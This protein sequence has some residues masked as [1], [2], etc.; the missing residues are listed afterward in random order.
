MPTFIENWEASTGR[1]VTREDLLIAE[2]AV[3]IGWE[4]EYHQNDIYFGRTFEKGQIPNHSLTFVRPER[5]IWDCGRLSMN[6]AIGVEQKWQCRD[7]DPVTKILAPK[8]KGRFYATI[9]QAL[10]TESLGQD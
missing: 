6:R 2:F 1:K 10:A 3:S 8:N 5:V 7:R 4:I 9:R